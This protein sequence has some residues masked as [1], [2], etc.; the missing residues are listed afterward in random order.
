M[1]ILGKKGVYKWLV[2]ISCFSLSASVYSS[3]KTPFWGDFFDSPDKQS[4]Q[5]TSSLPTTRLSSQSS[6]LSQPPQ[7]VIHEP[8]NP[9]SQ[10]V[11]V[12]LQGFPKILRDMAEL[13][14]HIPTL[15]P[16]HR[17]NPENLRHCPKSA[18]WRVLM[19]Y[20]VEG[21]LKKFKTIDEILEDL[22]KKKAEPRSSKTNGF[23]RRSCP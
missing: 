14:R 9:V 19:A 21:A 10:Q 13:E 4:A 16:G 22:E 11:S 3:E 15:I 6:S 12:F 8:M 2:L 1:N 23:H 18:D 5:K 17:R 7:R 20:S